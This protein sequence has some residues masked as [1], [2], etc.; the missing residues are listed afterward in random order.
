[1]DRVTHEFQVPSNC[2]PGSLN[3][4]KRIFTWRIL[5]AISRLEFKSNINLHAIARI[6]FFRNELA[7]HV[8]MYICIVVKWPQLRSTI[9]LRLLG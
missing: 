3:L 4:K 6:D 9:N 2:Q 5:A 8:Y 7:M 1:M